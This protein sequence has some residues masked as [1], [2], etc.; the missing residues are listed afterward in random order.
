MPPDPDRLRLLLSLDIVASELDEFLERF[1]SAS[2]EPS[3]SSTKLPAESAGISRTFHPRLRP[4]L[5]IEHDIGNVIRHSWPGGI[6]R[7]SAAIR[8]PSLPSRPSLSR[9]HGEAMQKE[10]ERNPTFLS[11]CPKPDR[12]LM[13]EPPRLL[14]NFRCRRFPL[15]RLDEEAFARPKGCK[16]KEFMPAGSNSPATRINS[17]QNVTAQLIAEHA[18]RQVGMAHSPKLKQ[19]RFE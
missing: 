1:E 9:R 11:A 3:G 17:S 13:P 8:P 14:L 7:N 19:K 5:T 12:V 10:E 18:S 16:A 4:K 15:F 6:R 2:F